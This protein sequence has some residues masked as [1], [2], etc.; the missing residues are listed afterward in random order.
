[1]NFLTCIESGKSP[2]EWKKAN[3]F[4]VHKKS[5]KKTSEN[6]RPVSLLPICGKVFEL[7][8]YNRLF[9]LF[10]ANELFS[11][12]QSSFTPDGSCINQLFSIT[13]EICDSFDD[14]YEVRG[15]F[16]DISKVFDKDCYNR[17]IY[18]LKP[19]GVSMTY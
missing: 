11:S 6:Y 5:N 18:K 7:L 2:S 3:V 19:N 13:H 9:E 14:E 1:M 16:F 4:P 8:I 15:V 17:L 12:N 10:I